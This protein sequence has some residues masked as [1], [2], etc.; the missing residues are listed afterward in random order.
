MMSFGCVNRQCRAW[1]SGWI[2]PPA[3]RLPPRRRCRDRSAARLPA[4]SRRSRAST[5]A[6]TS[7]T[8]SV[9]L[10][11]SRRVR[12]ASPPNA[13]TALLDPLVIGGDHHPRHAVWLA[14]LVPRRAG[15]SDRPAIG[16]RGLPGNRV[17]PYRAGIT[18]STLT[19]EPVSCVAIATVQPFLPE[20]SLTPCDEVRGRQKSAMREEVQAECSQASALDTSAG[21]TCFTACFRKAR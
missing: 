6:A 11:W 12:I 15:S 20:L 17:E 19:F 13:S 9:P 2:H 10:R 7:A 18:A 8:R 3:S 5:W 1:R 4:R 21:N 14:A 16:A